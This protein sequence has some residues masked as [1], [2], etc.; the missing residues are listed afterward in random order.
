METDRDDAIVDP[1]VRMIDEGCSIHLRD[2]ENFVNPE[3][4]PVSQMYV[5]FDDLSYSI[6]YSKGKLFR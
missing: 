6:C 2:D 5:E 4:R 1:T 3:V